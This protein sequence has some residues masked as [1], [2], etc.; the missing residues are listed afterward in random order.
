MRAPLALGSVLAWALPALAAAEPLD[1][2]DPTP[3]AIQI[4]FEISQ[5]PTV[6]GQ[7]WSAP[8]SATYSASGNTGTVVVS[9]AEYAAAIATK[10]LDYFEVIT[11]WSLVPGTATAFQV[12][13]D[14]TTL[15]ATAQTASY[16][17]SLDISPAQNGDVT[18]MLSTTGLAGFGV[19]PSFPGFP[20]FCTASC[21]IVPG[22]PYDPLT[23]RLNAVGRDIL[24]APD[25]DLQ[26]FSRA[27]DLRLSEVAA[28]AVPAVPVSGLLLLA[29]LMT[30]IGVEMARRA[31]PRA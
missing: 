9:A 26:S 20:F 5:S 29:V 2:S 16:E 27:G 23:G 10:N 31:Q 25:V 17:V 19:H 28:P 1:V 12:D 30:W 7:T 6:I 22:A 13:I 11:D 24:D 18:R 21:L 14:L 15:E 4:E 3:R 8:F